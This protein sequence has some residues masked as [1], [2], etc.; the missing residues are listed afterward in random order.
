LGGRGSRALSGSPLHLRSSFGMDAR[1]LS[2]M[3]IQHAHS[4]LP[5]NAVL[6]G[7]IW[8]SRRR[9]C[10][11][12]LTLSERPPSKSTSERQSRKQGVVCG[13]QSSR[14]SFLSS[15]GQSHPSRQMTMLRSF[16]VTPPPMSR[17]EFVRKPSPPT[18][19]CP[20][21]N[22]RCVLDAYLVSV[23]HP[24]GDL[25]DEASMQPYHVRTWTNM[26]LHTALHI[27]Y[28]AYRHC[29]P[30]HIRNAHGVPLA[31]TRM[32]RAFGNVSALSAFC[33][34]PPITSCPNSSL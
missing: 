32:D 26:A 6:R 22:L 33:S 16:G 27:G 4:C 17:C 13:T 10:S 28:M 24:V 30:L 2:L 31:G 8:T 1:S 21:R 18:R 29:M 20:H 19:C 23:V 14:S 9:I 34:H 3:H 11:A 7:T 25:S 15:L 12:P 5:P